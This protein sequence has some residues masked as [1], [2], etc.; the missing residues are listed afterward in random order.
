MRRIHFKRTSPGALAV[1]GALVAAAIL[2]QTWKVCTVSGIVRDT[3][4]NA[5]CNAVVRV[6]ATQIA[7]TSDEEGRFVLTGFEPSTSIR[8]TA[9]KDGYYVAGT[10]VRPWD[11]SAELMLTSHTTRDNQDYAWI[12]P[13]VDARP[14]VESWLV[15]E[16]ISSRKLFLPLADRLA[17]GCRDCHGGAI[18]DQWAMS[19]HG[20]GTDNVRFLTMYNG[21]DVAG[22]RSPRTQYGHS[23]D[24]GSFPLR[25]NADRPY[26]GPG[27]KLDFPK[28]AGICATCHLPGSALDRPYS[29]D[30]NQ[31]TGVNARGSHCDFCHKIA[32]VRLAPDTGLPPPNMPGI[33]S[34]EFT[35]PEADAQ[36]FFG[37][38]D[39][40]DVGPDTYSPLMKQSKVC[41]PCHNFSFWGVPIYQSFAEWRASSYPAE[42]KTCQS[43]HMKPDGVVT[44]FAPG[45]GGVERDPN[46]IATH[47][48]PGAA[49][50]ALLRDAVTMNVGGARD[51][52]R[53]RVD[54]TIVNDNTGHHVPTDSPLRHLILLV[55]AADESGDP[56]IQ[57]DGATL[58]DWCG[59]GDRDAGYYAGLPGTAYAKVLEERWTG[60]S[61]TAAYWNMTRIVSD[62]RIAAG[63]AVTSGF[64]FEVPDRGEVTVKVTLLFRRAFISLMDQKG[65]DVPDIAMA[66]QSL[67]LREPFEPHLSRNLVST[68]EEKNTPF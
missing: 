23:R 50:T 39:D 20:L 22:N 16:H 1:A 19:A 9:W 53:L 48:F 25:P 21:T 8:V 60:V 46:T 57:R 15:P 12:P 44:N 38:Y 66:Q 54:V 13:A 56:L 2:L 33:L 27:Y 14:A 31:V 68:C 35:R 28:T 32:G 11:T 7:A 67:V 55:E 43:C 10:N 30:P 51:T 40:V 6:K 4:G 24:Y 65:W 63:A 41:A 37:P 61:P 17:L 18:V 52:D 5:V 26:Y 47:H 42:G 49:D 29:V 64:T 3:S 36:L 59:V 45:R 34:L 58:P 62:N